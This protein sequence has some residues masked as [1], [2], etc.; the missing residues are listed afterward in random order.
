MCHF[1]CDT[2]KI[3]S[4]AA[5]TEHRAACS[6]SSAMLTSPNILER[7]KN[8]IKTYVAVCC[9]PGPPFTFAVFKLNWMQ[10]LRENYIL[11]ILFGQFNVFIRFQKP[12]YRDQYLYICLPFR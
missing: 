1:R 7:E 10:R 4:L 11:L 8:N 6:S 9:Y 3:C 2:L 12:L 5:G